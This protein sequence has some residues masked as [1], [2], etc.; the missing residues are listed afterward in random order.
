M[1]ANKPEWAREIRQVSTADGRSTCPSYLDSWINWRWQLGKKDKEEFWA[2]LNEIRSN[3]ETVQKAIGRPVIT[4]GEMNARNFIDLIRVH[5]GL[6]PGSECPMCGGYMV[7]N[8]G[9]G[10]QFCYCAIADKM[11][12]DYA[13]YRQFESKRKSTNT[14]ASFKTTGPNQKVVSERT[15]MLDAAAAFI[16]DPKKWLLYTGSPGTGKTHILQAIASEFGGMAFYF[17]CQDLANIYGQMKDG[18]FDDFRW[19]LRY[20]PVLILDDYGSQY[21]TEFVNSVLLD[22]IDFRMN[23]YDH[24]LTVIS[25]NLTMGDLT[26]FERIDN[27]ARLCD[28][29]TDTDYVDIIQSSHMTSYRQAHR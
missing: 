2:A 4:D 3:P 20:I 1:A 25:T 7:R 14:F 10:L 17:R 28:R 8:W 18:T 16:V 15:K 26:S 23:S 21:S 6:E 11:W 19:I 27:Y 13:P 29:I 22:V 24:W 9:L 5:K 12:N